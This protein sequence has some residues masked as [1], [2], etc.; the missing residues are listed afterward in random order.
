MPSATQLAW[1]QAA[2]R[3]HFRLVSEA[4]I[5]AEPESGHSSGTPVG[6][7]CPRRKDGGSASC[8]HRRHGEDI[9]AVWVA[10]GRDRQGADPHDFHSGRTGDTA[11]AAEAA[12]VG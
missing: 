11:A 4:V 2:V 8:K 1:L 9:A 6:K 10:R 7:G 12:W 5:T 3:T